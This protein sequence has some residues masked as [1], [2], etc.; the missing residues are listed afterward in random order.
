MTFD[1]TFALHSELDSSSA[2]T[3]NLVC[4]L[5]DWV[6]GTLLSRLVSGIYR[7]FQHID[8]QSTGLLPMRC[9]NPV[10]QE[11]LFLTCDNV[12]YPKY[13]MLEHRKHGTCAPPSRS[14][15]RRC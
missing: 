6:A 3:F 15:P 12:R 13:E 4:F 2:S 5:R 1:F 7:S 10:P 14:I 9:T 11:R 8:S